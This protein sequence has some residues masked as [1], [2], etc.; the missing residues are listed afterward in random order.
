[1][2]E[3][4]NKLEVNISFKV[5]ENKK[6]VFYQNTDSM[7][8]LLNEKNKLVSDK[9]MI[10]YNNRISPDNAVSFIDKKTDPYF[11]ET[12]NIDFNK[13]DKNI[14]KILFLVSIYKAEGNKLHFGQA[15]DIQ[16]RFL[17]KNTKNIFAEYKPEES[18]RDAYFISLVS[19]NYDKEWGLE[20]IGE[21]YKK[22]LYEYIN[23][24]FEEEKND[25]NKKIEEQIGSEAFEQ[26]CYQ[27]LE[28]NKNNTNEEIKAKY[29]ELIKSFHPDTIQS[30]NLH[31][32]FIEFAKKRFM[33]IKKAYDYLKKIRVI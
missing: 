10:F 2:S 29:K 30:A 7:I 8:L 23:T 9:H 24:F 22:D 16:I 12:I 17:D 26:W 28:C 21:G 13:I 5:S 1:M 15:S 19:F 32:D 33:D 6:S 31:K 18:F 11:L 4:I 20:A 3:K 25:N 27:T 14:K